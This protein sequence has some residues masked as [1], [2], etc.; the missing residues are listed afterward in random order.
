MCW[1]TGVTSASTRSAVALTL[2]LT[3]GVPACEEFARPVEYPVRNVVHPAFTGVSGAHARVALSPALRA[4]ASR[5]KVFTDRDA[6]RPIEVVGALDV[7]ADAG[8]DV[9]DSLRAQTLLLGG[10]AVLGVAIHRDAPDVAP[11]LTGVAVRFV[12]GDPSRVPPRAEAP[13]T[14]ED[15]AV[16]S[17]DTLDRP[18][19]VL[20]TLRGFD[21]FGDADAAIS[22]L[23][24]EAASIGANAIIG[25]T[26]RRD[27]PAAREVTG[28]A[29]R[30]RDVVAGRSYDLLEHV[31][32]PARSASDEAAIEQLRARARAAGADL[33]VNIALEPADAE[34]LRGDR[35]VGDAV[36]VRLVPR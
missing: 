14:A 33:I 4:L 1:A 6:R 36:H 34:S 19:E 9:L 27:G 7:E 3:L 29:V 23:R 10:D 21:E 8:G 2:A 18:S 26:V 11:W 32:V 13:L 30:Y 25:V 20:T 24:V 31:S 15:V 17:T 5:V 22:R 28:L 12:D 35:L 16:R